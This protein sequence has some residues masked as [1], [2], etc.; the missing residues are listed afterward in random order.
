MG[1]IGQGINTDTEAAQTNKQ[2]WG[3]V[4]NS[5]TDKTKVT[6]LTYQMDCKMEVNHEPKIMVMVAPFMYKTITRLAAQDGNVTISALKIN[7]CKL[8]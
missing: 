2:M 5:L 1:D 7:I 3:H 8:T 6:L 4:Y